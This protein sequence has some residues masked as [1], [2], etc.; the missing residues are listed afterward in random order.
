MQMPETPKINRFITWSQVPTAASAVLP[1]KRPITM[2]ST[3][4]YDS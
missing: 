1:A 2:V 3:I 4:L